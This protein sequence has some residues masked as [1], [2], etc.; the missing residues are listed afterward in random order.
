MKNKDIIK[1][2][3]PGV[4]AGIILGLGIGFIVGVDKSDAM[5]NSI[6]GLM[7]CF[8]ASS[9]NC[10]IV[11]KGTA[12]VLKRKISVLKAFTGSL[13]EIICGAIMGLLFHV[14][15][16]DKVLEYNTCT[17]LFFFMTIVNMILAVVVS[18]IMAYVAIKRYEKRVKYTKR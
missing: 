5:K 18:T 2:L 1:Q 11:V 16:L 14:I 4:I 6:G 3:V 7:A 10:T 15:I 12:K 13:V 8:I 9:L 17:F